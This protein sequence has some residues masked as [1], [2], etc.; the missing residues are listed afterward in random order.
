MRVSMDPQQ[1]KG[2]QKELH[3]KKKKMLKSYCH[4]KKLLLSALS[5]FKWKNRAQRKNE[6]NLML[7]DKNDY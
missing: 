7:S 1:K 6:P 5:V 2:A 3:K 4:L